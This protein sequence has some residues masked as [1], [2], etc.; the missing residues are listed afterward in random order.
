ME[1][2]PPSSLKTSIS[3]YFQP[4]PSLRIPNLG[5]LGVWEWMIVKINGCR[6]DPRHTPIHYFPATGGRRSGVP[7]YKNQ[8]VYEAVETIRP[9][10]MLNW[11]TVPR[12]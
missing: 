12:Q 9:L 6:P 11:Y 2:V 5:R 7:N 8:L 4:I 10:S 3:S 1:M